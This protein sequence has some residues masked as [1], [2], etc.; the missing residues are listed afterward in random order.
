MILPCASR[1]IRSIG[2]ITSERT[3]TTSPGLILD[4]IRSRTLPMSNMASLLA[5]AAADGDLYLALDLEQCAVALLHDRAHVPGL[6]EA[7]VGAHERATRLGSE[8]HSRDDRDP[9]LLGND[10]DVLH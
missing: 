8:R 2:W 4:G 6:A 3:W 10:V 9:V 1:S 7:D 5:S